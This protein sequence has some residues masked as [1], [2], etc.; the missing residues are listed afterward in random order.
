MNGGG[1]R[2]TWVVVVL[3][4][5]LA[6]CGGSA[7][8]RSNPSEQPPE[9]RPDLAQG[10]FAP[11]DVSTT[12]GPAEP[13]DFDPEPPPTDPLVVPNSGLPPASTVGP[14]VPTTIAPSTTI[15]LDT[16]FAKADRELESLLDRAN[17]S[18][19]SV[20]VRLDGQP[21][22][23]RAGGATIGGDD[24]TNDT[25]FPLIE[26]TE[27]ITRLAVHALESDGLVDLDDLVPWSDLGL[28]V[29]PDFADVTIGDLLAHD[30]GLGKSTKTWTPRDSDCPTELQRE[31]AKPEAKRRPAGVYSIG[32]YC[33]LG[34][35]IEH[36]TGR[37]LGRALEEL[38]LVPHGVDDFQLTT[39][40]LAPSDVGELVAPRL[41]RRGASGTAMLSTSDLATLF[42]SLDEEETTAIGGWPE[43]RDAAFYTGV[44][45]GAHACVAVL[46]TGR[47]VMT[48]AMIGDPAAIVRLGPAPCSRLATALERDLGLRSPKRQNDNGSDGAGS[49]RPTTTVDDGPDDPADAVETTSTI[50]PD[51]T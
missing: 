10:L 3:A 39:D 6:A 37:S 29:H 41:A 21:V 16:D 9:S 24:V 30:S 42:T 46:D 15:A 45:R 33:A 11:V 8:T 17:A 50:G 20:D 48:M 47:Y 1:S 4:V 31:L 25:P 51:D 36:V 32:N 19:F 22:F 18:A 13:F 12:V 26:I 2:T 7:R 14:T 43:D 38:V 5:V 23:R 28:E 49:G 27:S 40:E 44:V 35:V 34:L